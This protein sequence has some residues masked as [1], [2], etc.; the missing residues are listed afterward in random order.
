MNTFLSSVLVALCAIAVVPS[1]LA[2][3]LEKRDNFSN[4]CS[5]I[6]VSASGDLTATCLAAVGS[7]R[8]TISL[9][10]CVGNNNGDLTAGFSGFTS[11][12]T[13]IRLINGVDLTAQCTSA[14][15]IVVGSQLNLDTF[16]D[17]NN[18]Q[19]AC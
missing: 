9:N 13:N 1:I 5:D 15:G 2:T 7:L 8:S 11:S 19:L 14:S 12:C 16:V 3:P 10:N 17:N 4:S 6:S 18:G